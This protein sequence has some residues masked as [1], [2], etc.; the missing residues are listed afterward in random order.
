MRRLAL[1]LTC[2]VLLLSTA[3][4]L[5]PTPMSE[6]DLV[7]IP[8][9]ISG[10]ILGL[11]PGGEHNDLLGPVPGAGPVA[12]GAVPHPLPGGPAAH[13]LSWM[14]LEETT[15]GPHA[16][17]PP[18]SSS[19]SRNASG[20]GVAANAAPPDAAASNAD[21]GNAASLNS[22]PA[23]GV[24]RVLLIAVARGESP[25]PADKA[26][27]L[28]CGPTAG[29]HPK[30]ADACKQL[31]HVGANLN[32]LNVSPGAKCGKEYDPVT[33]YAAGLWDSGRLSYERTFTNRCELKAT[34]G[35]VF[36]F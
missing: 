4:A 15:L 30:A 1:G 25:T 12:T 7:V 5:S 18:G 3:A 20:P 23:K 19:A 36:D 10:T 11:L 21:L 28:L 22:A 31:E 14:A 34:A 24:S 32:D 13:L 2:A 27:L 33:V 35:P 29:S 17:A 8:R 16:P 9:P 6:R 26:V